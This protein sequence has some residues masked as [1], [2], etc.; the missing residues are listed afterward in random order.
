[1]V[2]GNNDG[3]TIS[4]PSTHS[5]VYSQS[6]ED[7]TDPKT[8]PHIIIYLIE[9]CL[10]EA[11][12]KATT[13]NKKTGQA[14]WEEIAPYL[15]FRAKAP[16]II[17]SSQKLYRE[18]T[19]KFLEIDNNKLEAILNELTSTTELTESDALNILSTLADKR[20]V[21]LGTYPSPL[22]AKKAAKEKWVSPLGKLH[23]HMVGKD[24]SKRFITSPT[25]K[26]SVGEP[27]KWK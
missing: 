7:K 3:T 20:L 10:W 22:V 15:N 13:Y 19:K 26:R 14:R 6:S 5:E 16:S 8:M 24:H 25:D 23:E 4:G 1:M 9:E 17:K 27:P 21:D 2:E 11:K 18:A 12:L